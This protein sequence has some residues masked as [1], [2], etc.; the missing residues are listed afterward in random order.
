MPA[1][2]PTY[3]R[4]IP[5]PVTAQLDS[6]VHTIT[7]EGKSCI[8]GKSTFLSVGMTF[9]RR[10]AMTSNVAFARCLFKRLLK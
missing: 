5:V 1:S 7:I 6:F 10:T 8:N 9:L 2:M 4:C 3:V